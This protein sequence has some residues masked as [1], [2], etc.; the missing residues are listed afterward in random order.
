MKKG[1]TGPPFQPT[2]QASDMQRPTVSVQHRF[3]HH[4]RQGRM[5]EN[6]V[7]Q[8]FFGGFQRAADHIA[9]NQVR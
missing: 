3:V 4:F 5:R 1:G 9:L 8:V 7:H 2:Y 6:R